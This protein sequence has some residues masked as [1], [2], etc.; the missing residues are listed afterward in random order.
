[1]LW[2][3][4]IQMPHTPL[5]ILSNINWAFHAIFQKNILITIIDKMQEHTT[6]RKEKYHPLNVMAQQANEQDAI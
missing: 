6:K 3:K 2:A 1:M 4:K 5:Q